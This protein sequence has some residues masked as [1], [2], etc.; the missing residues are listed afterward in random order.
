VAI[1]SERSFEPAS[2]EEP[3]VG[4]P[5]TNLHGDWCTR[6]LTS[7]RLL[8]F[9]LAD[10]TELELTGRLADPTQLGS[11]STLTGELGS[12]GRALS[13]NRETATVQRLLAPRGFGHLFLELTGQCNERCVHCY[14]SAAPEVEEALDWPLIERVLREAQKSGFTSVQFTGGDPLLSPHLLA[15]ARLA[16][17]LKLAIEVYTNGLAFRE[18]IARALSAVGSRLAFSFYSFDPKVHDAVTGTPGSQERTLRAILL[19]VKVGMSLRVAIIATAANGDQV[20][21]TRTFLI[22]QGVPESA[23]R[24]SREVAVGRGSFRQDQADFAWGGTHA[25][26]TT[27][28]GK[29]CVTYQGKVVPCIFDR[30]TVLG[31]VRTEALSDIVTRDVNELHFPKRLRSANEELSCGDCRFRRSLLGG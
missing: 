20:E 5:S 4:K 10:D 21:R 3:S 29:L 26:T 8:A 18:E 1:S 30:T 9:S 14:A 23:V 7:E 24:A 16:F 2:V 15:A 28:R 17:E 11:L 22:D 12:L 25:V 13:L 27:R 6:R 31:D 19:G